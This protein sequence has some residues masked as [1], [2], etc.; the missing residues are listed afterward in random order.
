MWGTLNLATDTTGILAVTKGGTGLATIPVGAIM[1]GNGTSAIATDGQFLYNGVTDALTVGSATLIGTSLGDVTLVATSTD[2]NVNI[3]PNGAGSV[4]I[5]NAVA[6]VIRSDTAQPLTIQGNTTLSLVSVTGG[7]SLVL[8]SSSTFK[9]GVSGPTDTEYATGLTSVDLTN[10][11]Y[12][13]N[14]AASAQSAAI[15][16][17]NI[18]STAAISA[19]IAVSEAGSV[20]SFKKVVSLSVVGSVNIGTLLPANSTILSVR[21]NVTSVTTGSGTLL[22][23]GITGNLAAYALA[24]EIYTDI[25][26]FYVS[27]T[28]VTEATAVQLLATVSGTASA[29]GSATV[30]VTY[31]LA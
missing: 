22:S 1:Y 13:D 5:G 30:V 21:T 31:R 17:A 2:A 28:E 25:V 26:G 20:K 10:K 6:A 18:A 12:V 16:A 11:L 27:E 19:A 8:P 29:T 23:V 7:T 15:L 24:S 14:T 3:L 9:I 4:I